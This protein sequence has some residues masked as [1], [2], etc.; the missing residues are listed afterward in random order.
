MTSRQL[1][2][3]RTRRAAAV[4]AAV[5]VT[6]VLVAVIAVLRGRPHRSIGCD[7]T[8]ADAP[9]CGL[10]WGAALPSTDRPLLRAVRGQERS[11]GRRLDIV[12]TYHRWYDTFPTGNE[13]A[14]ARAGHM[15]L[16]NWEPVDRTGRSM[17]WSDIAAGAHDREID[18]AAN[19]LKAVGST[20]FVSFSHEPEKS[21]HEHG[22]GPEFAA[23]F[24]HVHQRMTSDRVVNVRWVWDVMGLADPVWLSR[25]PTM[26][27]G[28]A[29][30]D[31]VAWDPYNWAACA[32]RP[33]LTFRQVVA[34]FYR[35]LETHGLGHKP[36]M[37][38]EYGT[39]EDDARPGAKA[40]WLSDIPTALSSLPELR[41]L[42][43]FDLPTPPANCDWQV[44]T[45]AQAAS[46]YGALA[47]SAPF[48]KTAALQR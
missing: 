2:R 24:R 14:V 1:A 15:L 30:V 32:G 44:G 29:Y 11:T 20:V 18:V 31:W 6:L 25:Y 39:V 21:F 10:W 7:V 36:F 46:A 26:W 27:P 8:S 48:M 41:A 47:R 3:I 33:W 42:L 35:W 12:H 23:A 16:I 13:L 34:P 28:D 22:T 43:Y 37:L 38:A 17:S 19:R 4:A 40:R 9:S 45:S 5:V